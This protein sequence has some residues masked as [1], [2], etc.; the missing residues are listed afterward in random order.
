MVNAQRGEISAELDG[1]DHTLC[2]TLGALA[3]LEE[4]L[5]AKNLGELATRFSSGTLS[6]T[7]LV[8]IIAAGLQGGG[9]SYSEDEIAQMRVQGGVA[10][11]VDI[12]A[13]LLSA[14]FTPSSAQEAD[15]G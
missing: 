5:G 1:K 6:A 3:C 2:L 8:T 9:N 10:G 7:E 11:F 12:A 14:T 13:R 15:V 4:R